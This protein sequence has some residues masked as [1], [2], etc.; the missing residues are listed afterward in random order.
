MEL[1]VLCRSRQ[2]MWAGLTEDAAFPAHEREAFGLLESLWGLSEFHMP[3]SR[4]ELVTWLLCEANLLHRR[5]GKAR[6]APAGREKQKQ[7][8]KLARRAT[9]KSRGKGRASLPHQVAGKEARTWLRMT[10]RA[11]LPSA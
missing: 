1:A 11:D 4:Q 9:R 7:A 3:Q 8:K 10:T 5:V 6:H 2:A